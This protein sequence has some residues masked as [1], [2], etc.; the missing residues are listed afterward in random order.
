MCLFV[1]FGVVLDL[2][3]SPWGVG[4][5]EFQPCGTLA[6]PFCWGRASLPQ[7]ILKHCF[8]RILGILGMEKSSCWWGHW[9]GCR[10]DGNPSCRW[11]KSCTIQEPRETIVCWYL[12]GNHHCRLFFRCRISSI[13]SRAEVSG[14]CKAQRQDCVL[15][16]MGLTGWAGR[17][18]WDVDGWTRIGPESNFGALCLDVRTLT[19]CQLMGFPL[20]H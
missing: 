3:S 8:W 15:Q 13:H 14:A 18:S 2:R 10:S 19:F 9:L 11:T 5:F 16:P 1:C 4:N 6:S 17:V 20:N 7:E 12:Q